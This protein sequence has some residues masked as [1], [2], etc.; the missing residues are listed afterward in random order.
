MTIAWVF[1]V[2]VTM[3]CIRLTERGVQWVLQCEQIKAFWFNIL[4]WAAIIT[5]LYLQGAIK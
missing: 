5:I 4:C 1:W 3:V 2:A